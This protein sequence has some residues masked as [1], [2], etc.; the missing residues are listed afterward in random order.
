MSEAIKLY[1]RVAK[2]KRVKDIF[3]I[4]YLAE[5]GRAAVCRDGSLVAVIKVQGR[6]YDGLSDGDYDAA[7]RARKQAFEFKS[8]Y[9]SVDVIDMKKRVAVTATLPEGDDFVS[10]G[11]N[12]LWQSQFDEV[13]RTYHYLVLTTHK[14]GWLEKIGRKIDN[15]FDKSPK[16]A[17]EETADALFKRLDSYQPERLCG[18]DLKSFFASL[19]NG[20]AT[21]VGGITFNDTIANQKLTF[22]EGENYCVYGRGTEAIYSAWLTI[23]SYPKEPNAKTIEKIF[24]LPIELNC[25]QS[26]K[27]YSDKRARDLFKEKDKHLSNFGE[28]AQMQMEDL[29]ECATR[30]SNDEFTL[31]DQYFSV[32]VMASSL[33][34]L[35]EHTAIVKNAIESSDALCYRES[36]NIEA[37]F[38]SRFP[39]MQ[40][41]NLR[42]RPITSENAAHYATLSSIGEG[43]D[44][45]RF[46]ARPVTLFKTVEN[47]QFSFTFHDEPKTDGEPLGHTAIIGD[48]GVGKT[49]LFTFLI[50]QCL[51]FDN[52]KAVLFDRLQGMEVF[53]NVFGGDFLD[54]NKASMINPFKMK[55]TP[56]N[57]QFLAHWIGKYLLDVGMY[58]SEN[59]RKI[60]SAVDANF[61]LDVADRCLDNIA[62][63][64]GAEGSEIRNKLSLWLTSGA[65]GNYFNAKQNAVNFNKTITTMDFTHLLNTPELLKPVTAYIFHQIENA[66]SGESVPHILG[67]DEA[68]QY[69]NEDDFA[70]MMLDALKMVRKKLGVVALLFQ[71]AEKLENMPD[72]IGQSV[73]GALANVIIYPDP[74]A[75]KSAYCDFLGLTE[76]EFKWIRETNPKSRQFLFKRL[77]SK[78]SVKL[79]ADLSVLNGRTANYLNAFASGGNAIKDMER[80]KAEHG[81][82]WRAKFVAK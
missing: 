75:S 13:F 70:K 66:V 51:T 29:E 1:K 14:G 2:Q 47:S 64:F 54:F 65:Y 32:E 68:Q 48:T 6:D 37:L 22:P 18:D 52:F 7:F 50:Q 25:Y 10:R 73:L 44:T 45:C 21:R 53:T 61:Q 8:D 59:Q 62:S 24:S 23:Q 46:G 56:V 28:A 76:S 17:L 72:G 79:N 39:T 71:N 81:E 78:E 5:K 77:K 36:T 19:V 80:A 26:F 16:Q 38:W 41:Y 12:H 69:F 11:V 49:T 9:V 30:Y 15:D 60:K 33:S 43:F 34:E 31:V 67:I 35:N 55:D 74:N 4:M 3:P 20:R 82:N 58:D 57:R 40:R 42:H 27:G 63:V